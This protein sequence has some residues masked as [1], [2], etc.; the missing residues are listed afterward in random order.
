M[1]IIYITWFTSG[2]YYIT[3]LTC[4]MVVMHGV[5]FVIAYVHYVQFSVDVVG[6]ISLLYSIVLA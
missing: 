2:V 4:V 6:R 3:L 1:S 5:L